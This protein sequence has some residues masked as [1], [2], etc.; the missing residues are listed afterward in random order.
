[1]KVAV[2]YC[3]PMV[4]ARVYYPLAKRF[5]ETWQR[6]PPGAEHQLYVG[7]NG[8]PIGKLEAQMFSPLQ[9]E[10]VVRDNSGWDIGLYQY[11][12]EHIASDLM[13]CLGAPVHF[14]RAGWL[15]RMVDAYIENGPGLYGCSA[16]LAPL[17]VRTT[18]FWCPPQILQ[19]YPLIIGSARASR[20][21]FEHGRQSIT[22]HVANSGLPC[23]MV[24][25]T[26]TY[27]QPEWNG[28]APGHNE[29]L[30]RDQHIHQ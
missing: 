10:F 30:V 19:S 13:V 17:H 5:V 22:R 29:I 18:A 26:G 12:A 27:P 3:Y 24:T 15:E 21:D 28:N 20:Y 16:Y 7:C 9:P 6:F 2:I 4:N 14:Y 11:A 25:W 1:M 8:S 23:L